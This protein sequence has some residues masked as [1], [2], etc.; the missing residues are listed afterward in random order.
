[1]DD[2]QS[3]KRL[4]RWALQ[5][6]ARSLLAGARVEGS[7]LFLAKRLEWCMSRVSFGHRAP[8]IW[9]SPSVMRA[10]YKHLMV[11]GSVWTCPIC[12]A[13]ISERRRV[14][15]SKAIE[16]RKFEVVMV[17][18]T[19][20]HTRQDKLPVSLNIL[21]K[22]YA[23]VVSGKRWDK[24]KRANNFVGSVRALEV[25]HGANG[26]HPHLHVLFFVQGKIDREAVR[27]FFWERWHHELENNNAVA[28]ESHGVDV[29]LSDSQIADYVSKWG[30][31]PIK[32]TL[33]KFKRGE[34]WGVAHEI[35]KQPAKLSRG[36][37]GRSPLQLLAD[38]MN[39]DKQAGALWVEYVRAFRGQRQ[40]VWSDKFREKFLKLGAEKSDEE[41]A[42]ASEQDAVLL[43]SLTLDQWRI[44]LGNDARGELLE[45]AHSGNVQE[46][47]RFLY[48]LGATKEQI[49]NRARRRLAM[50]Q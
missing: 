13:K 38:Y 48:R 1:M 22:S 12:A 47:E 33:D 35:A 31:E 30:H 49:E 44:V 50:A 41:I 8:D 9:Q 5:A 2:Q 45:V 3:K 42:K 46:V 37:K 18:F 43:Y 24:F 17:T 39:G 20:S 26:W 34:G 6:A 21:K 11:C 32:E 15:L 28:L 14:E 7:D 25:T 29:Q 16:S 10:H 40:L 19:F 4:V 27:S 23:R 36:D